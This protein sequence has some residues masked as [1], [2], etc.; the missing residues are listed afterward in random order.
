MTK[1][2]K[3]SFIKVKIPL[4]IFKNSVHKSKNTTF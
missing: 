4:S 1:I 3:N 2:F